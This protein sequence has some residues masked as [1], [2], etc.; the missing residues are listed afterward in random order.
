MGRLLDLLNASE[1]ATLQNEAYLAAGK[2]P[3]LEFANPS[4][5]GNGTDWQEAIFQTAPMSNHQITI[6][7]GGEKTN[8]NLSANYFSQDGIV[9]GPK[10]N[11]QRAAVRLNSSYDVQSWLTLGNNLGFTWLTRDGLT[12]NSQYNSPVIRAINMDP[13][14][15]RIYFQN[16]SQYGRYFCRSKDI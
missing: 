9:G 13:S 1:Y 7:G 11:F 5:L 4:V 2:T 8:H 14:W 12:E 15:K 3:P 10:A 6:S 16:H